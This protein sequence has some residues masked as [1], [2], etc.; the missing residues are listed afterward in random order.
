[1]MFSI[2]AEFED[3]PVPIWQ[4]LSLAGAASGAYHGF[5][6][7]NSVGWAIGWAFLG[8]AFPVI[9]IPVSLAQGYGKPK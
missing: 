1:M 3:K 6:R 7:N 9:T 2:A 4:Y 5:R 8:G